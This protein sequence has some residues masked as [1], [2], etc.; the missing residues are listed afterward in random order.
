MRPSSLDE[1]N[2]PDQSPSDRRQEPRVTAGGEVLLALDGVRTVHIRARMVDQS[3]SG[4]RAEHD[5]VDLSSGVE[6]AFRSL[7]S[8]GRAR[9]VWTRILG[10]RRESGFFFLTR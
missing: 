6:V 3:S 10:S 9:V 2:S 1:M 4:F 5:C 7:S 8:S